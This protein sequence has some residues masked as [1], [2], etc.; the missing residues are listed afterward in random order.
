VLLLQFNL[1]KSID[2]SRQVLADTLRAS[3]CRVDLQAVQGVE[4]WGLHS[5]GWTP[6]ESR[7][8]VRDLVEITTE[9]F[10]RRAEG[11]VA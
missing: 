4:L 5:E 1:R 8:D 9:W 10:S 2:R 11:D 3:G 7:P 6:I